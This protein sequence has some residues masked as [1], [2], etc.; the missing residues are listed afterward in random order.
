MI[1]RD[2]GSETERDR[3]RDD[4][5][6]STQQLCTTSRETWSKEQDGISILTSISII[7]QSIFHARILTH[8]VKSAIS[9]FIKLQ[10]SS[11]CLCAD[12]AKCII[13]HIQDFQRAVEL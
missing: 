9:T 5:Q 4:K 6:L 2:R 11:Y 3:H 1:E 13:R 12:I 8:L 7:R 10:R